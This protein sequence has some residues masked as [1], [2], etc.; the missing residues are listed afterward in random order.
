MEL[1]FAAQQRFHVRL[2]SRELA[3]NNLE[4]ALEQMKPVHLEEHGLDAPIQLTLH[5]RHRK[6]KHIKQLKPYAT[7]RIIIVTG[8]LMELLNH[9]TLEILQQEMS[10]HA[11][12]EL[13][14]VHQGIGE[15]VTDKFFQQMKIQFR[16]AQMELTIT[17]ITI[18]TSTDAQGNQLSKHALQDR[19]G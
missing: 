12:M 15:H 11:M 19:A 10:G 9:A 13:R 6:E 18:V 7:I 17:A 2:E 3:Q 16:H 5:G 4:S 1:Q 8:Q 14:F